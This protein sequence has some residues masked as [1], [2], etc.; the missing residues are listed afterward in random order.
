MKRL[1]I[2]AFAVLMAGALAQPAQA[3]VQFG[4]QANY[5][6]DF[7]FGIGARAQFDL[8]SMFEL[9]GAMASLKGVVSGDFYFPDCGDL[10]CSYMEINGNALYPIEMEGDLA[11]Y[12]G[13]GLNI[14]RFS[15]DY[16]DPFSGTTSSSSDTDVGLNALGGAN[17][18][19]G[20]MAAFAE[21]KI[22]LGGG[23]QFV[24]TFGVLFG[25]D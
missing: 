3:Q 1:L 13:G 18:D 8:G 5:A 11:P 25:G 14:A 16:T 9:E 24:L 2:A 17:F 12:V 20:S 4:A 21:A 19:L 10:D 22:E 7:D 15:A 6:D 23:E